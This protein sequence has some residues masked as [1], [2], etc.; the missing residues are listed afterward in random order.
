MLKFT[1]AAEVA[2]CQKACPARI[3]VPRYIRLI[4]QGNFADALAVVREKIPFPSVCG[5]VCF[6]PCETVCKTLCIGGPVAINALKRFAAEQGSTK[7][8]EGSPVAKPSGKRVAIIG[9]GPA[10]LTASYY[11]AK[12][13][14]VVTVFE[15]LPEPGGMM[16]FGI[17]EYRLPKDVLNR[18]I[19]VIQKT[20]VEIRTGRKIEFL[21]NF[22][23]RGYQAVFVAIGTHHGIRMGI[24][25]EDDP[26]V[27]EAISFLRRVKSGEKMKLG[28]RVAV[29]GGGNSAIDGAR[30]ALRLGAKEVTLVYRRSQNEMPANSAEVKEALSEGVKILFLAAPHKIKRENGKVELECIHTRLGEVDESGRRKPETI[31]GT[32]FSLDVD[33]VISAVGEYPKVPDTF[34]L[35]THGNTLK[36]DS[37]TLATSSEGIFAGGDVV[38]GS[39]SVIEA[40]AMGR[41]AASSIDRYLGGDGIIGGRLTLP[42]TKMTSLTPGLPVGFPVETSKLPLGERLKGFTEVDITYS[43]GSAV[44]EATRCLTCDLPIVV[45]GTKCTVCMVCQMICS[46]KF[47]GNAFNLSEAAIKLKRTEQGTCEIEFTE[48]CD[49]C[50][51]CARYCSYEAL[52]RGA[53]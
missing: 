45:D 35:T 51:L 6:R 24:E 31:P 38:T 18:E 10:G 43:E 19:E 13:G 44:E 23:N 16:R 26:A 53:R 3:D 32:E 41:K 36:V 34:G 33:T 21:D 48:K 5:R 12:L 50:G 15:T 14:H 47:T 25:G 39:A 7:A 17:P 8:L 42:E 28:D 22:F 9:S 49:H 40:I 52:S 46:F 2:P 11:L 30:T 37:E 4:R 20:G 27:V 1:K 29:I